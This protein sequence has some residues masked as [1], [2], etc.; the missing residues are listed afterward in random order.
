[1][2]CTRAK[3]CGVLTTFQLYLREI[4]GD[5]SLSATEEARSPRQLPAETTRWRTR[6]ILAHLPLVVKI[7]RSYTGRGMLL[8]DLIGEGNLGLIRAAEKLNPRFGTR[9][10]TYAT[11]WI[12]EAILHA[13]VNTASTIRLPRY[14]VALLTKWRRAEGLLRR[15]DGRAL[16]FDEVAVFLHLSAT[17]RSLVASALQARRC[18]R[19]CGIKSDADQWSPYEPVD[20]QAQSDP[21]RGR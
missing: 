21:C 13:C 9:F 8:D 19:E 15:E 11:F 14:M 18:K 4:Q 1:M 10:G 16:S 12:K 2:R 5:L 17:Q 7:A 3:Q 6:M 20:G